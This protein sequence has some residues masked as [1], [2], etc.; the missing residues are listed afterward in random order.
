MTAG[1]NKRTSAVAAII[2]VL[3]LIA[4][5]A[6]LVIT[7][8]GHYQ[9]DT[10]AVD[11]H[12]EVGSNPCTSCKAPQHDYTHE[13]PYTGTCEQCHTT[14]SWLVTHY[15]HENA[16]FN[17]SFH[18]V[19][20]CERCHT[21][22][23]PVPSP[24]CETCHQNRSP[25]N[26]GLLACE[27][28]HTV[29]AWSLQRPVPADHLSLQGGHE[30]VSCFECHTGGVVTT[31]G[32]PRGCVDCH[33][34][35]HGGLRNCESCHDPARDWNPVPGWDH[36]AFFKLEGRHAQIECADCHKNGQFAG[37]PST[38]VGC[39][40]TM[41]GGL[42][43][44]QT[45]HDPA[46]GWSPKPGWDHSAFFKLE[47]KHLQVGCAQC[48]TNNTFAGTPTVC[49]GCHPVEH[50]N[51]PLC[52]QCH[53][54]AGFV[55]SNFNHDQYFP[56][57]GGHQKLACISCHP[58]GIYDGTPTVC[59]GCHGTAHG[60]LTACQD[61][62]TTN[63]FVPSTFNHTAR[64]PLVGTHASLP[65]ASCH[66]N[67]KYASNIGGGSTA[68]IACH[69]SPHGSGITECIA[70]HRPTTWPDLVLA[71][72]PGEIKLGT[73]H[74]ARPCTLCHPTLK[75]IDEAPRPCQDC[76]LA[77]V[78]HVGP[79]NC[80]DCHRPTTWAELHF[81]HPDIGVHETRPSLN[82]YCL[83]CHP[84]PNF[85][86]VTCT[87]CH[88]FVPPSV[89]PSATPFPIPDP[90]PSEPPTESVEPSGTPL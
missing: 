57:T 20:G 73:A 38:C 88:A 75:F 10:A 80:I 49:Q 64:F 77:D 55:P 41:H 78:P 76:H 84:G 6:G 72:H 56:I 45:C 30:G 11:E 2:I 90:A 43:Q 19:I 53:T 14:S 66:P 13:Q 71:E 26:A 87:S 44:C 69:A 18:A 61:C 33:G 25:H 29:T 4:I 42:T 16:E 68:C 35:N 3:A 5:I 21:E 83:R 24:A 81:T 47:G 7:Q 40:G 65:C 12:P 22:G 17:S 9:P 54:P 51:L 48:H 63:G 23:E 52:A 58:Q 46:R 67:N 27:P 1:T 34:E 79:T 60:G 85:T 28:C 31:D 59:T 89:T 8:Y 62:H 39:H 86:I 36:S 50:K 70:C 82:T 74:T 15:I 32:A 37:T